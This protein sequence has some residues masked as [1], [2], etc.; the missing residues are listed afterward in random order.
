M[1]AQNFTLA[2]FR[3]LTRGIDR[4]GT[5][6]QSPS[7]TNGNPPDSRSRYPAHHRRD[8]DTLR[9]AVPSTGSPTVL[10]HRRDSPPTRGYVPSNRHRRSPTAPEQAASDIIGPTNGKL[11]KTRTLE[12]IKTDSEFDANEGQ[13]PAKTHSSKS[14]I[15]LQPIGAR[16]IMVN[17]FV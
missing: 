15:P 8:S 4:S 14:I 13:A 10:E 1:R 5:R 11:Q 3:L 6:Q 7:P 16:N 17:I 2:T 9:T 12:D